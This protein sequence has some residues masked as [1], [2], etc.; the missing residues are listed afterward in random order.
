MKSLAIAVL[1]TAMILPALPAGATNYNRL[2]P[3]QSNFGVS[4]FGTY[5]GGG[6]RGNFRIGAGQRNFRGGKGFRQGSRRGFRQQGFRQG[7]RRGAFRQGG[8]FNRGGFNRRGGFNARGFRN[9]F[10]QGFNQFPGGSGVFTGPGNFGT[11]VPPTLTLSRQQLFNQ[12]Y[13]QERA[14]SLRN[15]LGSKDSTQQLNSDLFGG[16]LVSPDRRGASGGSFTTPFVMP[17][18]PDATATAATNTRT[19]LRRQLKKTNPVRGV[20]SPVPLTK[21]QKARI[22]F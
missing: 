9:G 17:A 5:S 7:S 12:R 8:R 1:A 6:F 10:Q 20:I 4:S 22:D 15:I 14:Q 2:A 11:F 13:L 19:P 16:N 21:Q 18:T 3:A